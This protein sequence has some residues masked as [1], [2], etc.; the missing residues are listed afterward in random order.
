MTLCA[1]KR[2]AP[3]NVRKIA[4]AVYIQAQGGQELPKSQNLVYSTLLCQ[5]LLTLKD[6]VDIS[7]NE[8]GHCASKGLGI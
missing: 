1:G 3:H 2:S 5:P 7:R 4:F 8:I 6:S